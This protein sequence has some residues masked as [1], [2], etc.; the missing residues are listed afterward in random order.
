MASDNDLDDFFRASSQPA[1]ESTTAKQH[2]DRSTQSIVWMGRYWDFS[3]GLGGLTAG[4]TFLA[5]WGY[6]VATSG[7]LLG[8]GLGWLPAAI[9]A[10]IVFFIATFLW[11]VF[12]IVLIILVVW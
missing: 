11:P 12:A 6:C 2:A 7:F 4:I 9:L 3:F 8:F 1:F 10:V 5:A